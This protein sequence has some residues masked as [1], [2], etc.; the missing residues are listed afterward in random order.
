MDERQVA[1]LLQS[2]L[3]QH[4]AGDLAGAEAGYRRILAERPANADALHLLGVLLAQR[5]QPELGLPLL[6]RA[7]AILP[8]F[9]PFH[10]H[11]GQ[12]LAALN[13]HEEALGALGRATQMTPRDLDARHA[14]GASLFAL[15]RPALAIEQ[16]RI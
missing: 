15:N 14:A 16:F 6:Q 10:L 3:N 11:F 8:E 12:A 1:D 7:I 4:N 5:G 13:R 2:A 9:Q